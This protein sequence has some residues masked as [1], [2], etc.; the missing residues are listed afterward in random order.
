MI[1]RL[2]QVLALVYSSDP[3]LIP[4]LPK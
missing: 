2:S 1:H 4:Y 3:M